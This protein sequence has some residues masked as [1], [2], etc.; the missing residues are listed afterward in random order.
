MPAKSIDEV[1]ARLEEIILECEAEGNRLGYFAALYNRVT[2]RVKQGIANHEFQDGARMERLDVTFA[3]RYLAA[4]DAYRAGELPSRSWLK[5]F[6]EAGN[7][8]LLVLQHLLLGMNAHINLDLGVAAARTCPG[9]ELAGLRADFDRIN[10]ILAELT[11][12][13]EQEIAEE[14]PDFGVIER[15]APK[16]ETALVGFAMDGARD[17]AWHFAS[18]LAP[19]SPQDQLPVMERR[20]GEVAL[21]ACALTEDGLVVHLIRRRES[22]DVAQ[23]IRI[24]ATGEFTST[25]TPA[26]A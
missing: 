5:A 2:Q 8:K 7:G 11:P 19:L 3:N 18:E 13:V 4:Y 9:A 14:S 21:L 24:L 20:D 15:A 1:I 10:Q 6:T 12:A 23:N 25:A 26:P 17:A 16:V 22:S